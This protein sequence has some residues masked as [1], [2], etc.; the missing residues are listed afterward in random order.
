MQKSMLGGKHNDIILQEG[1]RSEDKT[2]L[3]RDMKQGST[4]EIFV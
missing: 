2:A 4:P 3:T 1:T